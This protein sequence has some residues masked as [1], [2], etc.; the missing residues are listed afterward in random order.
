MRTECLI[1]SIRKKRMIWLFNLTFLQGDCHFRV[2]FFNFEQRIT[3]IKFS[4]RT[5]EERN[6]EISNVI[7][8]ESAKFNKKMTDPN[9]EW[10][11]RGTTP[12]SHHNKKILCL[13][14]VSECHS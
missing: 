8:E 9:K 3:A 10:T 11:F 6:R 13:Q 14:F 4:L 5:G 7:D 2:E 1:N 12:S